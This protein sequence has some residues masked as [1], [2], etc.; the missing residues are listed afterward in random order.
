VGIPSFEDTHLMGSFVEGDHFMDT[1][2]GICVDIS[3]GLHS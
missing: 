1:C 2:L 3:F